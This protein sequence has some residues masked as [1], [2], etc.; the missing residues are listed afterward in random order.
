MPVPS[1]D[2]VAHRRAPPPGRRQVDGVA[3]EGELHRPQ[4]LLRCVGDQLFGGLHHAV[5]IGIGT[6][7]LDLREF[8]VVL[9][10]NALVAE[11]APD[12]VDAVVHADH[13]PV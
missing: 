9:I 12:F 4:H 6:V 5:E 11:V 2:Q 8:G 1:F 3:L 13:Q 10:G 7:E